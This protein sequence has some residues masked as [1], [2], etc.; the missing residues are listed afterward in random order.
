[1][2]RSPCSSGA[3]S[4][5]CASRRPGSPDQPH[6]LAH[7]RVLERHGRHR[8]ALSVGLLAYVLG[9]PPRTS[10]RPSAVAGAG[11]VIAA[12]DRTVPVASLPPRA[13]S[14]V[15]TR[16]GAAHARPHRRQ[17]QPALPRRDDVRRLG[18]RRPRRVD[19]DHP[20]R[21]R[22]RD[23]LHRH[24]RRVL[25]RRV[26]GDRRQGARRRPARQRRARHQGPRHDGRRPERVRQ[27]APLDHPARSRTACAGCG[28]DWIDLY[29]I[30]RP[31]HD[32]DIDETLGALTDLVRQGKVRYIGSSTFPAS[33]I[34]EAQWVAEKRGRER[35]VCEQPPYSM[36]V[37]GDRVRRAAH[38]PALRHGRDPVEP[39]GR[40][41]AVGQVPQG[42][43]RCRPSRARRAHAR[44]LRHVDPGQPAQ[45]RG[46]R[47]AGARS[48]RRRA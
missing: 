48:P 34:V 27:L 23:Q 35:F 39:A 21:A 32:T 31:E 40:R 30:H 3:G 13:L 37:R 28:T 2:A 15:S 12:A 36:L 17:G 8:R 42:R 41:L 38:L 9:P 24:R 1:M 44:A 45:A 14:L 7:V 18:Q 19:P 26:G 10:S 16:D 20:P 4:R 33:Q 25:A 6:A 47:R 43:G 22:R 46:G 11:L 29:Q 5:A